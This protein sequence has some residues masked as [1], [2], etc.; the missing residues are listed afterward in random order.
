MRAATAHV[1]SC[2]RKDN[3][4]QDPVK[5]AERMWPGDRDVALLTRGAVSPI[6]TTSASALLSTLTEYFIQSLSG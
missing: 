4:R 2:E 3:P 5:L 6:S 1:L